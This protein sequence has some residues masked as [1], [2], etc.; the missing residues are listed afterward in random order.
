MPEPTARQSHLDVALT[1]VSV[2]YQNAAYIFD[3]VFPTIPVA[4][5]TNKYFVFP[6]AAW[7]RDETGVRAPG[8]RAPRATYDLS[9]DS[10]VCL[11]RALAHPVPDEVVENSDDPLRPL[12]RGTNYVT[13]QLMKKQEMDVL[14]LV[15]GTGWSSSATPSPTWD[16][17]TADPLGDIETGMNTVA[18]AIGREPN[19]AVIGR[20]L[21]RYIKNHPDIVDRIKGGATGGNPALVTTQNFAA[22]IEMEKVL[23]AR[24]IKDTGLEGA[25]SSI[26]YIGGNHMW[27]GYVTGSAALDEPSAGYLYQWKGREVNRYREDQEH[28]DVVE[29]LASWDVK[30]TASDAAYLIKSAA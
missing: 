8:T 19:V 28:Q 10:Y 27:L 17:D 25:A 11:E 13:D 30:V 5:Q 23:I 21:W 7:Y 15:F 24:S 3:Q 1:N 20:G 9:T 16:N 2:A 26:S 29:A 22:L 18:L 14:D 12:V 6:K 4:K